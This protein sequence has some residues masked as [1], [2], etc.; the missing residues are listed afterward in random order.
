LAAGSAPRLV[1]VSCDPATLA[2][3]LRILLVGGTYRVDTVLPIDL[4]P[5]TQHIECVVRLS[6]A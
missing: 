4:F 6:R 5:H 1:Y 3:D 2:R